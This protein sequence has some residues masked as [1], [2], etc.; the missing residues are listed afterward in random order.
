MVA[1]KVYDDIHE[2]LGYFKTFHSALDYILNRYYDLD[3]VKN[4]KANEDFMNAY[5]S[6]VG[7]DSLIVDI[8]NE[9][10]VYIHV[11]EIQD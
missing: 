7:Y 6:N 2:E 1:Y 3:V 4:L 5:N 11:I 9:E 8:L 10:L